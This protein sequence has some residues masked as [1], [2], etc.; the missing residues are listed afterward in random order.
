M[1]LAFNKAAGIQLLS[2]IFKFPSLRSDAAGNTIKRAE[3]NLIR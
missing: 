1:H 2:D 3:K